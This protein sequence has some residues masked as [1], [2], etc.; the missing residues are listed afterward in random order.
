MPEPRTILFDEM[1]VGMNAAFEEIVSEELVDRFAALSG[2]YNPLHMDAT[3]AAQTPLHDRIPHGMIAGAFCSRLIGMHLPG[4]HSLYLTQ[5][6][7]FHRPLP[8]GKVT[9]RGEVSSV[10]ASTRM[11][12]IALS[13]TD[14]KNLLVKGDA[15]VKMLL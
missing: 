13:I 10:H 4:L 7:T 8:F 15:L 3:Y 6:L 1:R 11:V 14:G 5:S 9:V 2:D 12:G